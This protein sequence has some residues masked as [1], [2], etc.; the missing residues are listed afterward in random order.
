MMSSIPPPVPDHEAAPSV[1]VPEKKINSHNDQEG[2]QPL[3]HVPLDEVHGVLQV[4]IGEQQR[5]DRV[6]PGVAIEV[7]RVRIGN[8]IGK[9]YNV[10]CFDIQITPRHFSSTVCYM[11]IKSNCNK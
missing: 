11:V 5:V 2:N 10:L 1:P 3:L 9:L 6:A 7:V 8:L 4:A